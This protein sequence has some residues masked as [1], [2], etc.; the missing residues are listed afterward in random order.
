MTRDQIDLLN[1]IPRDIQIGAILDQCAGEK[2]TKSIAKRRVEMISGNINSYARI[3]N[4]PSQLKD[5]QTYNQLAA[6]MAVVRRERDKKN[7]A[8]KEKKKMD[9]AEKALKKA[10]KEQKALEE[11]QRLGPVCKEHVEKGL[12]HVLDLRV[13]ARKEI[14]RIHFGLASFSIDGVEVPIYKLNK[15]GSE[16]A[17]RSL[18]AS[19]KLITSDSIEEDLPLPGLNNQDAGDV[20]ETI[21]EFGV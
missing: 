2:A 3:L 15:A 10:E 6:S 18:M 7:D 17:L 1:P 12:S 14:L 16:K 8:A 5:I 9:E 20:T 13:D 4:G 19:D 11:K 21:T